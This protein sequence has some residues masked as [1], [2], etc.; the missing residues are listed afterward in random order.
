M[1]RELDVKCHHLQERVEEFEER[2][3]AETAKEEG[4]QSPARN[5][6][7]FTIL[8]GLSDVTAKSLCGLKSLSSLEVS[9]HDL[10]FHPSSLSYPQ[11]YAVLF[12]RRYPTSR[13]RQV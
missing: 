4:V 8:D 2:A 5:A 12:T 6:V 13:A 3:R 11:V 9:V 1:R 7:D 10:S